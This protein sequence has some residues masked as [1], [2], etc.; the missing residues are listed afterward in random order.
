MRVLA[1]FVL[2]AVPAGAADRGASRGPLTRIAQLRELTREDAKQGYPVHLRGVVTYYRYSSDDLFIQDG[3]GALYISPPKEPALVP[4]QLIEV[5]GI[6]REAGLSFQVAEVKLRVVGA[7]PLPRPRIVSAVE[8]ST[9]AM[10]R[11]RV[12]TEGVVRAAVLYD[13][14]LML[15]VADPPVRFKAFVPAVNVIPQNLLDATV[16]VR[17][18]S[19]GTYNSKAQFAGVQLLIPDLTGVE[20]I[21][22]GQ[23]DVFSLPTRPIRNVIRA[24]QSGVFQRRVRVQGVV[25]LQRPGRL[26][27][28]SDGKEGLLVRSRQATPVRVGASVDVAGY[29]DVAGYSPLLS[30]AVFQQFGEGVPPRAV[31]VTAEEALAGRYDAELIRVSGRLIDGVQRAGVTVLSL[32][33]GKIM[34]QAELETTGRA[35]EH[36]LPRAAVCWS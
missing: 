13:G 5:E 34:F 19:G 23:Q 8:L 18:T 21:E 22:T 31:T 24:G 20:V 32:H 12:Q 27:Y 15:D 11:W 6:A 14:G 9:G 28:I 1:A 36:T 4:G 17:G 25:T 35:G 26:L 10:D 33:A 2:A 7:A 3:T 29:P 16:R 30:D